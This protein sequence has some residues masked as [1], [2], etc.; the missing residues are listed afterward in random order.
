MDLLPAFARGLLAYSAGAGRVDGGPAACMGADLEL[1]FVT[2]VPPEVPAVADLHCV[3]QGAADSLGVGGRSVPAH[4]LDTTAVL[5]QPGL[6]GGRLAVGQDR[7]ASAGLGIRD[8]RGVSV[9]AAQGEV[10][11]ADHLRDHLLRHR[12]AADG[13]T[14]CCG[15][16]AWPAGQPCVPPPGRITPVPPAISGPPAALSGADGAPS[17][18]QS[19]R[20]RSAVDSPARDRPAAGPGRGRRPGGYRPARP[21]PSG[22]STRAPSPSAFR[23]PDT[24]PPL[25]G[26]GP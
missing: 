17:T 4:D 15:K 16:R 14:R 21:S 5:P 13:A 12:Q 25:A 2:E 23:T 18:R 22:R 24:E 3:G 11:H 26:C 1:D 20:G 10:V 19:A 9:S 8:D 6:E 7:D